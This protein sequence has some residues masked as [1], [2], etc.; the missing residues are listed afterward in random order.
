MTYLWDTERDRKQ[1]KEIIQIIQERIRRGMPL[2]INEIFG[3][4]EDEEIKKNL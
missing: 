2:L 4:E 1:A 3:E